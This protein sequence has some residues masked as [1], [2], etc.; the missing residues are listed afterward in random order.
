MGPEAAA[1]T[2]PREP[3]QPR[4]VFAGQP[5][6][7]HPFDVVDDVDYDFPC[8]AA[9]TCITSWCSP[10]RLLLAP[11]CSD[12]GLLCPDRSAWNLPPRVLKVLGVALDAHELAR[13]RPHVLRQLFVRLTEFER[14][15]SIIPGFPTHAEGYCRLAISRNSALTRVMNLR[16]YS[17]PKHGPLSPLCR[18]AKTYPA[19]LS[20]SR[21]RLTE[22]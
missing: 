5:T 1:G 2:A 19:Q 15:S 14:Y 20:P 7:G 17:L 10:P 8:L 18:R 9:Y 6:L 12:D 13:L 3:H 16:S 4:H 11:R 22:E 21:S